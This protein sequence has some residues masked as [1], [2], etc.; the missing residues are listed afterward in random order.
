MRCM[1]DG[2]NSDCSVTYTSSTPAIVSWNRGS[3]SGN[4]TY[5]VC[6]FEGPGLYTVTVTPTI[7]NASASTSHSYT[8]TCNTGG[9]Y[10]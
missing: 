9:I 3:A 10:D 1:F 4:W 5:D 6:G 8:A 7:S 2:V